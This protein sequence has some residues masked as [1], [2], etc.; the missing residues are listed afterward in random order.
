MAT[1]GYV[2]MLEADLQL[3][4]AAQDLQTLKAI[5]ARRN[6]I[7]GM[8]TKLENARTRI[9]KQLKELIECES[10]PR[11]RPSIQQGS[12][13]GAPSR[14]AGSSSESSYK[15][16]SR[17]PAAVTT[18]P[19]ST[20]SAAA[21]GSLIA[22][23]LPGAD[24]TPSRRDSHSSASYPPHDVAVTHSP[25]AQECAAGTASGEEGDLE[26]VA[27]HTPS[28]CTANRALLQQLEDQQRE[29]EALRSE[30]QELRH[31]SERG[32]QQAAATQR[33]CLSMQQ[34]I[35][36][37]QE[38]KKQQEV[39]AHKQAALSDQVSRLSAKQEQQG[40]QRQLEE[41]QRGVVMKD[42]QPL[43]KGPAV[44]I[45]QQML[46]SRVGVHV[47]VHAVSPLGGER[48][49]SARRTY[50]YKVV[51]GSSSERL[52]VLQAKA[53]ALKGT[54]MSIDV[55]LTAE[56]A[57]R[58]QTLL[59]VARQAKSD[60][61]RVQWRF[62]T[63]LVDGKP[64]TGTGSLPL[65]SQQSSKQ[66]AAAAAQA[67]Q[68]QRGPCPRAP[69]E[70]PGPARPPVDADGFQPSKAQ[71]N[72]QR[73]LQAKQAKAAATATAKQ[74]PLISKPARSCPSS[75][76][77]GSSKPTTRAAQPLSPARKRS[78][79]CSASPN[80]AATPRAMAVT[81]SP[82]S[83][84]AVVADGGCSPPPPSSPARA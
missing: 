50:A 65:P 25:A 61:R 28:C 1:T 77:S 59:P 78:S 67:A 3:A 49:D 84:A 62:D 80:Q 2:A 24:E 15:L 54:S 26:G 68:Q 38:H 74:A 60:G 27:C 83:P 69:A 37:L 35:T 71:V 43:P 5:S 41:C 56:Q 11:R 75:P 63:L 31:A 34:Q 42:T 52:A 47:T 44:L 9:V 13:G 46:R 48:T 55:L 22:N 4:L 18:T 76:A 45:V 36:A 58:K 12:L 57:R 79:S 21:G 32:N 6:I 81:R 7:I 33:T 82:S 23:A 30:V 70:A 72:K 51:L 40:R 10:K 39:E 66:T 29:I 64:Y 14:S 17:V 73:K 20:A 8:S 19:A 53:A 16:G